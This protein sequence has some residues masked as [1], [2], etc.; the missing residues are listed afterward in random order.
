MQ[1]MLFD[2][3]NRWSKVPRV[4]SPIAAELAASAKRPGLSPVSAELADWIVSH[5][6]DLPHVRSISQE[7][8]RTWLRTLQH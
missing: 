1:G 6:S 2:W 4:S 8:A 7:E 3:W 5:D